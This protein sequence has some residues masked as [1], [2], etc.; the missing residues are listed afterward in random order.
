M[1]ALVQAAD[2]K[3]ESQILNALDKVKPSQSQNLGRKTTKPVNG[4]SED[5]KQTSSPKK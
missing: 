3:D 1:E 2:T 5:V 4:F